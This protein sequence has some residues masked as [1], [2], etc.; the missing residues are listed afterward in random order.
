LISNLI[1]IGLLNA[2]LFFGVF[3]LWKSHA[4]I[5]E[6]PFLLIAFAGIL[7]STPFAPPID[8]D[9]MRAYAATFPFLVIITSLG[10][11]G[12]FGLK[13]QRDK[14]PERTFVAMLICVS[15]GL[16]LLA[17]LGPWFVRGKGPHVFSQVQTVCPA[18]EKSYVFQTQPV[19]A[20]DLVED[21]HQTFKDCY[22]TTKLNIE[23]FKKNL[24]FNEYLL[25]REELN[26]VSSGSTIFL[27]REV[28]GDRI[29]LFVTATPE[30]ANKKGIVSAC[31]D[32][33][34][35][36]QSNRGGFPLVKIHAMEKLSVP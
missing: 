7:L 3:R 36:G 19:L 32:S 12:L 15:A 1:V 4:E 35:V 16:I 13:P 27:G 33:T 24:D 6:A 29:L 34:S 8:A 21:S 17:V 25:N 22:P 2:C 30:A 11:T 31:G 20:V 9:S 26:D 10:L 14:I 23:S 5:R 28:T 18:G